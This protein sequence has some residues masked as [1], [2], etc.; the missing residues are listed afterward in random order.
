M[1]AQPFGY[2]YVRELVIQES[3]IP[4]GPS[5]TNFPLLV[6]LT[7]NDLRSTV[8]GGHVESANGHDILFYQDGCTTKLDHQLD[9]Y[10]PVNGTLT[11]WV[12]I[13]VLSTTINSSIYLY[14]G[15]DTVTVS[16]STTGVWDSTYSGV[17]H[18]SDNPG[19]TAPQIRDGAPNA[20]HGTANGGMTIANSVNGKMGRALS[21]DEVNDYVRI[22]DFLYG[23]E[24]TVS[25]WFNYSEVNGNAYQYLF[26]HGAWSTPNSLN[27][28]MGED[29]IAIPA[30]IPNRQML[31][32]NF[33]DSNDANN[34]DTLNAG[35]TLVDGNWHYYTIR[36]Q[37]FGG[38]TIYIDGMQVAHYAVW[39]ANSFDP[40]TDIFLGGREDLHTQRHFGGLLDEV[41]ISPVWRTSNWILTEYNNQ[42]S[43]G[44]FV[45]SGL[46]GPSIAFCEPLSVRLSE[47]E[48][49]EAA[50][51]VK[52]RWSF[53]N[54]SETLLSF[55]EKSH[56]GNKWQLLA[57]AKNRNSFIDST[58][59][60]G[61]SYYRLRYLNEGKVS[62][63]EIRK[64]QLAQENNFSSRVYPNP[65][66]VN[67]RLYIS[68][69]IAEQPLFVEFFDAMGKMIKREN[70]IRR[71]EDLFYA[72]LPAN[73]RGTLVILRILYKEKQEYHKVIIR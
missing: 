36:I 23:Q 69:G 50:D 21:F 14:Y 5:L 55:V 44:L 20:Y 22:P 65:V 26:S 45:I 67:G 73:C 8:N 63:S 58:P 29:N 59:Y 30:E 32:T 49:K 54:P 53:A 37:D 6:Q 66:S 38:A 64:V 7:H 17:W 70:L 24:L 4:N 27:V 48:A 34:F 43:P 2:D 28:Y 46:E 52:L 13:P 18:L 1:L 56:D 40:A 16:N 33:R 10:D 62:Y 11:A 15:N 12:R 35:N 71:D 61:S 60:P 9:T 72:E 39:G 31:K 42:Q 47:F 41:R 68:N 19:G 3:R 51:V 25:F 57:E